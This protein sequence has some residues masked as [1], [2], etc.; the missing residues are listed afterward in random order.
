MGRTQFLSQMNLVLLIRLLGCHLLE[1][2]RQS[3]AVSVS[4][5]WMSCA[6]ERSIEWK[7]R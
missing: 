7:W 6:E 2:Q 1:E 5:A 4:F 3:L